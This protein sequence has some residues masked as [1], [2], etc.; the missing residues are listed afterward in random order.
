[1]SVYNVL[2][3]PHLTEKTTIQYEDTNQAVFV[4]DKLANKQQI[5]ESVEKAFNVTVLKVRTINV[6]GK[7]KRLGR[8]AGRQSDWKKALVTLKENDSIEY[9]G[10]A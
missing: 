9:F 7:K 10:G 5:K 8:H 4:V 6:M 3:K 1:M 2:R